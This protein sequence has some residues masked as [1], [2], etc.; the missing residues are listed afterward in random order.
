MCANINFEPPTIYGALCSE[1]ERVPA[2]LASIFNKLG[3]G[4]ALLPFFVHSSDLKNTITCLKLIDVAALYIVGEHKKKLAGLVPLSPYAKKT[5]HIDAIIRC[6]GNFVGVDLRALTL[7]NWLD[8]FSLRNTEALIHDPALYNV[9]TI[10]KDMGIRVTKNPKKSKLLVS[11]IETPANG[12][13]INYR[14][15]KFEW[16]GLFYQTTVGFLTHSHRAL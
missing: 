6:E 13:Q 2:Q 3:K 1:N 14:L 5:G 10:L 7:R 8:Q 16:V 11:I 4:T 9:A 15:S 12:K